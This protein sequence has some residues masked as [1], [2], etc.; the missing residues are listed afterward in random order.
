MRIIFLLGIIAAVCCS[1]LVVTKEY[2]EYLKRHVDWEV[3]EYEDNIFRGMTMDEA[4]TLFGYIPDTEES[5][6]PE[7]EETV[8]PSEINWSGANC[9]VGPQNQGNCGSCWAFAA[10]GSLSARCCLHASDK[11]WLSPQ[12]LVSCDTSN[13]ACDGG[14]IT[15]P[16]NYM[17]KNNGL[18][19]D[20]CFPY[21]A[22]KTSCPTKCVSG[23]DFK[24]AHVCKCSGST[25]C[26]G[27][28]GI[29]SCLAKGPVTI[30]FQVCKSF[31]SYK[32]GIYMCDC[33]NFEGGH[34]VLVMGQSDSPKCHYTIRNSWGTNWGEKGYF[35]MGCTTCS[36][37]G[38]AVCGN[39][40]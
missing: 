19:P 28:S 40:A 6:I 11:G 10:V 35:R 37:Q 8:T 18:V 3:Q 13:H 9:D 4:K 27:T 31:M 36:L 21:K 26:S 5:D 30:G 14:S 2:V 39:V 16:V 24:S 38:G 1:S 17:I 25:R 33:T 15:S 12:E 7:V 22:A 34:A 32:S 20:T 29:K 23:G